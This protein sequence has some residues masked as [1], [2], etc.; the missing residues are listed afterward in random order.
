MPAMAIPRKVRRNPRAHVSLVARYRSPTAFEYVEEECHDLSLGGMF[1]RSIAPAPAGT[2]IKLE[3]DLG[4]GTTMIRGVARVVWLRDTAGNGQ[5]A[6]MGV[7]FVK[8][9]AGGRDAIKGILDQL[10]AG[11]RDAGNT[12]PNGELLHSQRVLRN[13]AEA[14]EGGEPEPEERDAGEP[15]DPEFEAGLDASTAGDAGLADPSASVRNELEL[16]QAVTGSTNRKPLIYAAVIALAVAGG[17]Y[18]MSS[19]TA[20]AATPTT[21]PQPKP[22]PRAAVVEPIPESPTAAAPPPAAEPEVPIPSLAVATGPKYM[23]DVLTDPGG[24]LAQAGGQSM[25]TP[26]RFEFDGF[27]QP[28]LLELAKNGFE[29]VALNID[30]RGFELEDGTWHRRLVISLRPSRRTKSAPR[31]APTAK[32]PV[33]APKPA[34]AAPTDPSSSQAR[35]KTATTCLSRGDNACVIQTLEGKAGSAREQEMLIETYRAV[36]NLP[37]AQQAMRAYVVKYPTGDRAATY[38]QLLQRQEKGS[39]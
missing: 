39:R 4:E 5:P 17:I 29:S 1:I 23:L 7:K 9:E 33:S 21:A 35:L 16:G 31:P 14:P 22:A 20:P 2:L 12:A 26:A 10:A 36:S 27:T 37:K 15:A 19:G 8:L 24:A 3:C 28:V 18:A 25:P 6:G 34:P 30:E 38:R 32:A 13:D 11:K